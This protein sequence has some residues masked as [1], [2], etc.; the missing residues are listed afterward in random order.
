MITTENENSLKN[1]TKAPIDWDNEVQK[2]EKMFEDFK[3]EKHQT[4]NES[5]EMIDGKD[6]KNDEDISH[7]SGIPKE[8]VM[9]PPE[10]EDENIPSD[11]EELES[12]DKEKETL[13][14]DNSK[15]RSYSK[16]ELDAMKEGW[17]PKDKFKGE[18]EEW[19]S[20]REYLDRGK[21]LNFI[22][23]QNK[24]LEQMR[25]DFGQFHKVFMQKNKND[26][27]KEIV[28][29]KEGRRRAIEAGDVPAVEKFDEVINTYNQQSE[30]K[31]QAQIDPI[32]IKFEQENLS[33]FNDMTAENKTMKAYAIQ[34][35][36]E[37][38]ARY[39][40][41]S[42]AE[43]LSLVKKDTEK[44]FPTYFTKSSETSSDEGEQ[45]KSQKVYQNYQTTEMGSIGSA[46]SKKRE[47]TFDDLPSSYKHIIEAQIDYGR[48]EKP[49]QIKK[50]K[51]SYAKRLLEIGEV[52]WAK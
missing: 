23:K 1:T 22:T 50:F 35:D 26:T 37:Y 19:R 9:A 12:K 16:V 47:I 21:L 42:L 46:S 51:D 11:D 4:E 52:R 44:F 41:K 2:V 36:N 15:K 17:V 14:I 39:P 25:A 13:S 8:K 45:K 33:W 38:I 20:A 29:L 18:K 31:Q 3:N 34:K 6:E 48:F 27:A 10:E 7:D 5:D 40:D 30:I 28:Q 32:I 24:E 49:D 43:R